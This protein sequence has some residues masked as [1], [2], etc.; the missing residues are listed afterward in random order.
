MKSNIERSVTFPRRTS[1]EEMARTVLYKEDAN[2]NI[3]KRKVLDNKR[4]E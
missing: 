1:E 4:N 2:E 3:A